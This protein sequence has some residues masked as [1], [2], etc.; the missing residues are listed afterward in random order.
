MYIK[1]IQNIQNILNF[2]LKKLNFL[3]NVVIVLCNFL[4]QLPFFPYQ[5]RE[6]IYHEF[7]LMFGFNREISSNLKN[8]NLKNYKTIF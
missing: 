7:S 2:F 8:N 3:R 1:T 6:N 5:G 4:Y